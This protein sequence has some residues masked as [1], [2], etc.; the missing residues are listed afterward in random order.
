MEEGLTLG[1]LVV[2]ARGGALA[3]ADLGA[4][5]D[6]RADEGKEGGGSEEHVVHHGGS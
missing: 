1:D 3:N 4:S 6:S 2:D 5:S